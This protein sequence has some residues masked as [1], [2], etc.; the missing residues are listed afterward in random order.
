MVL[1]GKSSQ[2]HPVNTGI[3]Q[4]SILAPAF[5]LLYIKEFSDNS[6]YNTVIYADGTTLYSECDQGSDLWQQLELASELE[7]DQEDN[8][9][10]GKKALIDFNAN[11]VSFDW[12][13]N[14]CAINVKMDGS[15]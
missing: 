10:W 8:V 7:A 13:N 15:L 5:F 12:S 9:D 3:S 1:D 4:A 6:I 2:E 11:L 14:S